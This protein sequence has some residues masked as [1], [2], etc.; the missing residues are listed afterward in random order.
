ML[1][2]NVP[3]DITTPAGVA[4]LNHDE[5]IDHQN[6]FEFSPR[7]GLAWRP[8]KALQKTVV[9]V[10]YGLFWSF[11]PSMMSIGTTAQQPFYASTVAG[12]STNPNVTFQNPFPT[13]PPLSS[14]LYQPVQ[15]GSNQT[16][17]PYDPEFKPPHTNQYS[18]NLQTEFRNILFTAGYVGSRSTNIEFFGPLNEA[19]LASPSNPIHG[20][21]TN[22]LEI[23]S[24]ES[25]SSGSGP[26]TIQ[27]VIS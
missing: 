20:Q 8:F 6:W 27:L 15:L 10:G 18:A 24:S 25:H 7:V 5:F 26:G 1:A 13:V 11:I 9:R 4:K 14:S 19:G 23:S 2:G 12:G 22:T 21:T 16:T 3:S 17:Y